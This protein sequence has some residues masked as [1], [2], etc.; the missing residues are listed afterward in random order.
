MIEYLQNR[1][2]TL[3]LK[4]GESS[5]SLEL[6]YLAIARKNYIIKDLKMESKTFLSPLNA[7]K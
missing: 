6:V 7:R 2:M 1:L 3:R 5:V 4:I